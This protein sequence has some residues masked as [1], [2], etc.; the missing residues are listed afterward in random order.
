MVLDNGQVSNLQDMNRIDNCVVGCV[1]EESSSNKPLRPC[2]ILGHSACLSCTRVES[3][4][5]RIQAIESELRGLRLMLLDSKTESN[6]THCFLLRIPPEIISEI[7]ELCLSIYD[8][9]GIEFPKTASGSMSSLPL[10]LSAVCHQWRNIACS[11]PR[12]WSTL[13]IESTRPYI[14]PSIIGLAAE[15]LERSGQLPLSITI[16]IGSKRTSDSG[17]NVVGYMMT[18]SEPAVSN[19]DDGFET[20]AEVVNRYSH[21]WQHLQLKIPACYF[22]RFRGNAGPQSILRTIV[23]RPSSA[24]TNAP[25]FELN[26]SLPMIQSFTVRDVPFRLTPDQWSLLSVLDLHGF[27]LD[28]LF[29]ILQQTPSLKRCK[30]K[31]IPFLA[32]NQPAAPPDII[33]NHGIRELDVAASTSA[34]QLLSS[35]SLPSLDH[36]AWTACPILPTGSIISMLNRSSCTLTSLTLSGSRASDAVFP[37][38]RAIPSLQRLWINFHAFYSPSRLVADDPFFQLLAATA[39]AGKDAISVFL[40]QLRSLRMTMPDDS[41][42]W[43]H[44]PEIFGSLSS[45]GNVSPRRPLQSLRIDGIR[46][47]IPPRFVEHDRLTLLVPFL[48]ANFGIQYIDEDGRD[49]VKEFIGHH[50]LM[51]SNTA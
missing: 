39:I 48:E 2:D 43:N 12:L 17:R 51:K 8:A 5:S 40:P 28:E 6:N 15:W 27:Q 42:W 45:N 37:L 32:I 34:H 18:T 25:P 49:L 29:S 3:L 13:C 38:L 7:F 35:I 33:T 20:L 47:H 24:Y 46:E 1:N 16:N 10:K 4:E 14:S 31:E 19:A 22:S 21:R 23:L 11:T 30:L 26:H 41:S 44:V 36:F 9:E 50:N